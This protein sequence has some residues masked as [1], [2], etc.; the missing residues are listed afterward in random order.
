MAEDIYFNK[1]NK[2]IPFS[3]GGQKSPEGNKYTEKITT[4]QLQKTPG[5][6]SFNK[7]ITENGVYN[8]EKS[9]KQKN[10]QKK[11]ANPKKVRRRKI[12]TAALSAVLAFII[13][14]SSFVFG[15][16]A[17]ILKDYESSEFSENIHVEEKELMHSAA[18]YNILLM[19]IDTENT[20]SSSRSDA[21]ILLSIDTLSMKLKL[22]SFLRD[23]YVTIP[24]HGSAKLNAACQYG[25]P[26]LV[27]DTIEYNFGVRIDDYAK[28]G[29]DMF[30]K[31][32]DAVGG[33][34]IPE[35]DEAEALALGT[36]PAVNVHM[37]GTEALMYCRIRKGQSDFYRTSRQREV[38]TLV[39]KKALSSDPSVLF[40]TAQE[41]AASIECSINKSEFAALLIKALP[42]LLGD[43]EQLSVP[44]DGTWYDATKNS[45]SVLMV[46]FEQ[47][48]E[49][50][51]EFLY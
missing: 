33:V 46:D 6:Y 19:G 30:V 18:V 25:G 12:L 29:Y 16:S 4:E 50:I 40:E 26:Q 8:T 3:S 47:N 14:M 15:V 44:F 51:K 20:Q 43:I 2:D 32:I 5:E 38:I 9:I 7:I 42:C 37:N 35:V 17:F 45:Q 28:V 34:T 31:I 49:K 48:K 1:K 21:M 27:C 10:R 11:K 39:L 13:L 22:T 41:I 23:S 24:G 36:A